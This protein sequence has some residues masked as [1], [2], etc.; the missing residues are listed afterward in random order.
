MLSIE[1]L[2]ICTSTQDE[3]FQRSSR[4]CVPFWVS[5]REQTSGRGSRGRSW[6]SKSG[7]VYLSGLLRSLGGYVPGHTVLVGALL[8][9]FLQEEL[10]ASKEK[11]W[12]KWPNDILLERGGKLS[13]VAGILCESSHKGGKTFITVGIGINATQ[14]SFNLSSESKPANLANPA[15]TSIFP[16][17]NAFDRVSFTSRLALY[18]EE[19]WQ[20]PLEGAILQSWNAVSPVPY[21]VKGAETL[22]HESIQQEGYLKLTSATRG[23]SAGQ[24]VN[25][26]KERGTDWLPSLAPA[27]K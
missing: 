2:E 6:N 14:T 27:K 21:W 24:A 4:L 13:K 11:V 20:G 7:G 12:L 5:A 8:A 1:H 19:N 18:I 26:W 3:V 23:S 15:P 10:S 17:S 25:V 22:V 16:G 9:S